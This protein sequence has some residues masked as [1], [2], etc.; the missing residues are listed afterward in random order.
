MS[1][2]EYKEELH[3]LKFPV[4]ANTRPVSVLYTFDPVT[5][6]FGPISSVGVTGIGQVLN[7]NLVGGVMQVESIHVELDSYAPTVATGLMDNSN[8]PVRINPATEDTLSDIL[9]TLGGV[10]L[11]PKLA[12]LSIFNSSSV[13]AG[14]GPTEVV[15]YTVPVGKRFR[16][17]GMRGWADVDAE[18][19]VAIDGD[20]V[21]GYRTTPADLT[22]NINGAA[23]QYAAA[24]SVVTIGAEHYKVG[25]PR[26]VK[27]VIQGSLET[28]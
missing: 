15:S 13:T 24:G 20:Q 19:T 14:T 23:I 5:G 3:L 25:I 17:T 8:P 2:P 28:L 11:V 16:I 12:G 26:L 22:M 21:D 10:V 9:E 1:A 6:M 18:F 4:D 7:T 27:A